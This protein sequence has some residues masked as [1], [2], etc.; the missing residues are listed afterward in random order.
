MKD[1]YYFS[2]DSN[3]KDDPK[4]MMVI[5][6]MGMEGYGIFWVLIEALRDQPGYIYPIKLLPALARRYNTTHAKVETVVRN[7]GLF[8]IN[9]DA[10]FYSESLMRRME[11]LDEKRK[12][13]IENSRKGGQKTQSLNSARKNAST[14]SSVTS[15]GTSSVT[16]ASKVNKSK[17]KEINNTQ[18]EKLLVS[19]C[20]DFDL[21]W[22]A[23]D[24]KVDRKRCE[25][26]YT[27]INEVDRKKIKDTIDLY[28]S[29]N[30]N[31]Q[32]RKNPQTY[33]NGNCWDDDLTDV[34]VIN[35]NQP[36]S[37]TPTE[38]RKFTY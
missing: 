17:V 24:K 33:L 20:F 25:S 13:R 2:H 31:R 6:E 12:K 16:K 15:S 4:I 1:A 37:S 9:D 5:E 14:T 10:F 22:T 8:S 26:I 21:F 32:Y 29:T 11:K 3:A 36:K 7:Y 34:V 19:T 35:K 18:S 38:K 28:V 27:K 30:K 23:Y